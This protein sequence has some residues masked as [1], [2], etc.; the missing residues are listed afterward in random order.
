LRSDGFPKP[1]RH[2]KP[3]QSGG[4]NAQDNGKFGGYVRMDFLFVL[5]GNSGG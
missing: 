4:K 1:S 2:V 5:A 3:H